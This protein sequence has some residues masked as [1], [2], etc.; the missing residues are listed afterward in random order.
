MFFS[1][2]KRKDVTRTQVAQTCYN[3]QKKK[4]YRE[5]REEYFALQK[6]K[7]KD[8]LNERVKHPNDK[9]QLCYTINSTKNFKVN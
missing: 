6:K 2:R 8:I 1:E 5:Q 9:N 7:R 3:K 4:K